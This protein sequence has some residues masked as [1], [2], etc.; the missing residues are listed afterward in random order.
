MAALGRGPLLLV[1]FWTLSI[2][3]TIAPA[4]GLDGD[5]D[6]PQ[7]DLIAA[8]RSSIVMLELLDCV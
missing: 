1:F 6:T 4:H 5:Y 2:Q 8:I 3:E 7:V